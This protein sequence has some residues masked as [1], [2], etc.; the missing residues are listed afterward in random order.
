MKRELSKCKLNFLIDN[1]SDWKHMKIFSL[2]KTFKKCIFLPTLFSRAKNKKNVDRDVTIFRFYEK[3]FNISKKLNSN[4]TYLVNF[5][6]QNNKK[7]KY[8]RKEFY[9]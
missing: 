5:I 2:L 9:R 7:G 1:T 4:N 8:H 6:V 3:C